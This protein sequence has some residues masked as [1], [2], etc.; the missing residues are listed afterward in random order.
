MNPLNQA[1]MVL[2]RCPDIGSA[3]TIAA[4]IVE[5]ELKT[6]IMDYEE[7]AE[8][9]VPHG[10]L[11]ESYATQVRARLMDAQGR[12]RVTGSEDEFWNAVNKPEE[13]IRHYAC[14][15]DN[16]MQKI[17]DNNHEL[18]VSVAMGY[19]IHEIH[20]VRKLPGMWIVQ[21]HGAMLG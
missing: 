8:D 5:D 14:E 16:L 6:V 11:D 17:M 19:I 12:I 13:T 1:H 2:L 4:S 15:A 9:G 10:W 21:I 7:I 20:V 3:S 18:L